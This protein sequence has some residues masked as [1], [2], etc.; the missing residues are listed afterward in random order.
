MKYFFSRIFITAFN[1][2][3]PKKRINYSKENLEELESTL[4]DFIVNVIGFRFSQKYN[5]SEVRAYFD[6]ICRHLDFNRSLSL[7]DAIKKYGE[8][9][10]K[11][12]DEHY[13]MK[14]FIDVIKAMYSSEYDG[15]MVIDKNNFN[16]MDAVKVLHFKDLI[17]ISK[18]ERQGELPMPSIKINNFDRF[19]EIL[20]NYI[21]IIKGTDTYYNIFSN[22]SF[23]SFTEEEK[24]KMIFEG[25]I[26][27]ACSYE[28][29]SIEKFFDKY[30]E[31]VLD[32]SFH[33]MHKVT[34]IGEEFDDEV[35][36][37]VKRSSISYE[38]PYYFSF[39]L[40]D[41][42][43][44]L[45][46]TRLAIRNTEK[47]E[48]K[49]YIMATQS[50]QITPNNPEVSEYIKRNL[51][52]T[53]KFRTYNPD[54]L[55]SIILTFGVLNGMGIKEVAVA[56]Y[57][58][59]RCYKTIKDKKMDEQ[60]ANDYITRVVDKNIYTYFRL[61]ELCE[62][63]EIESVPDGGQILNIHLGEIKCANEFLDNL[64]QM[65]FEYGR[66]FAVNNELKK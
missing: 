21:E 57:M 66:N 42:R 52:R 20:K 55:I 40:K 45:P 2:W 35:Y 29:A 9:Y 33:D 37:A 36:F 38:T 54:H 31:F 8:D 47:G 32:D 3:F 19:D 65:A 17:I 34:K 5:L 6:N 53:A 58:P 12:I 10:L 25:T 39:M 16:S 26:F 61:N 59:L 60:S 28:F 63:L 30:C 7:V 4:N 46:N 18:K 11:L 51:P 49:A 43:L 64:Y 1:D 44:E 48:K 27:N 56:D 41:H 23:D 22:P 14:L 50:S 13:Y 62:G 24:I 15:K